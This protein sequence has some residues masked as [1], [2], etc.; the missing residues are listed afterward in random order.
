MSLVHH[1]SRL[2]CQ[3]VTKETFILNAE[4]WGE[5]YLYDFF[6]NWIAISEPTWQSGVL[7]TKANNPSA[8]LDNRVDFAV[9][10]SSPPM[11]FV[12]F[13]GLDMVGHWDF[14]VQ[15]TNID[16]TGFYI[17]LIRNAETKVGAARVS[18]VAI[19]GEDVLKRKNAWIGRFSTNTGSAVYDGTRTWTGHV[20]FGFEFK[21]TPRIFVGVDELSFSRDRGLRMY[22]GAAKVSKTGLD[23]NINKW[24]DSVMKGAGASYLAVDCE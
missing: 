1:S 7:K 15:A 4:T 22:A 8:L 5:T 9:P 24:G 3:N 18:W 12:C 14:R 10:F 23:W 11:I 19:P 17:S 2:R 13:S 16:H 21:R 6:A 20:K